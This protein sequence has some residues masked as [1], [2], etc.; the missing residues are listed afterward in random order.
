[1]KRCSKCRAEKDILEFH[2]SAATPDGLY[3]YC[4]SCEK[5]KAH[6]RYLKT[7]EKVIARVTT[8]NKGHVEHRKRWKEEYIKSDLYLAR[9]VAKYGI[10]D[11][12]I[13]KGLLEQ[14]GNVCAICSRP[15]GSKGS[16]IDHDHITGKVRGLLCIS[17][18]MSLGGFRDNIELLSKAIDYLNRGNNMTMEKISSERV[19]CNRCSSPAIEGT[20]PP[21]C[22]EHSSLQKVGESNVITLREAEK[23]FTLQIP[24]E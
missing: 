18:N 10:D 7:R 2:K 17:C 9:R 8:W 6:N 5:I 22:S 1:M 23:L 15:F 4:K 24:E 16:Q 20:N 12:E 11:P 21:L 14:Q 3:R 13:F 19:I